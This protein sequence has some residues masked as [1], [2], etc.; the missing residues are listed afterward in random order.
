MTS[1]T[2][3]IAIAGAGIAGLTAALAFANRGFSVRVFERSAQLGEVGAGVQLSANATRILDRLGV[4]DAVKHLAVQPVGIDLRRASSGNFIASVPL[5]E[6]A[7]QRW[8]APYLTIHRADLH[9]AL[10]EAVRAHPAIILET[11]AEVLKA[12]LPAPGFEGK[13]LLSV[14]KDGVTETIGCDLAV[15][16]DGVHSALR[17]TGRLARRDRFSGFVAWRAT[18]SPQSCGTLIPPA[19][20]SAFLHPRFHLIAYPMRRGEIINL[21]TITRMNAPQKSGNQAYRAML[22]PSVIRGA[23]EEL[24]ALVAELDTWLPWPI[25]E[26]DADAPWV[27]PAGLALIGDAAHAMG[28]YAAQGAVMA[29]EDAAAL[30]SAVAGRPDDLAGALTRFETVRRERVR[31]VARR[32]AFNRFV[33][34]AIGPVALGR[35]VVLA[36]RRPES[37]AADFDWLYGYDAEAI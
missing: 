31:H 13:V 6:A 22:P 36:M 3:H 33:W 16:A 5:G 35:D 1:K 24:D 34:H 2:R 10:T 21:V 28:P 27:E 30:A 29:I 9:A 14:E 37:L 15:G 20:V 12:Q 7:T 17:A 8:G 4:L 23:N 26:V 32:G 18:A 25:N 11:E 19:R